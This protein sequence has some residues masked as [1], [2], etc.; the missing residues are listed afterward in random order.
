MKLNPR[1]RLRIGLFIVCEEGGIGEMLQARR[2]ITHHISR[3]WYIPGLVAVAMLSLVQS[4]DVAKLG[5]RT[6][7]RDGAFVNS[8]LRRCVVREVSQGGVG[9]VVSGAHQPCL[10]DQGTVFQITVG[11]GSVWVGGAHYL[12]LDVVREREPPNVGLSISVKVDSAHAGL[13]CIGRAQ[14]GRFLRYYLS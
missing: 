8:R 13:G 4:S 1:S 6:I 10:G 7:I 9:R 3:S 11:D 5:C 12:G 14:E 2:I